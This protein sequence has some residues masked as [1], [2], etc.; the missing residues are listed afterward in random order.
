MYTA[1]WRSVFYLDCHIS[2]IEGHDLVGIPTLSYVSFD[3]QKSHTKYW[4]LVK[5]FL[6]NLFENDKLFISNE[7][8]NLE[9]CDHLCHFISKVTPCTAVHIGKHTLKVHSSNK[10]QILL[11]LKLSSMYQKELF[12]SRSKLLVHSYQI[13]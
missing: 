3:W 2:Y 5:F 1:C 7:L 12:S 10:N 6:F 9:C 11:T 4:S 13:T 8:C